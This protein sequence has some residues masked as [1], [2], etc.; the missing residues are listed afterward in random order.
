MSGVGGAGERVAQVAGLD[1]RERLEVAGGQRRG[2]GGQE[3]E[4]VEAVAQER[5]SRSGQQQQRGA[6]PTPQGREE[7]QR[8]EDATDRLEALPQ[9]A[10][11]VPGEGG[12]IAVEPDVADGEVRIDQAADLV[13]PPEELRRHAGLFYSSQQG[14]QLPLHAGGP[15]QAAWPGSCSGLAKGSAPSRQGSEE[16]GGRGANSRAWPSVSRRSGRRCSSW[17]LCSPSSIPAVR[18]EGA[19][20]PQRSRWRCP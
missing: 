9:V 3:E 10:G 6:P 4:E 14:A 7:A 1:Q 13:D 18:P 16:R 15:A 2:Q 5:D 12:P 19:S 11:V 20:A 8:L 17:R